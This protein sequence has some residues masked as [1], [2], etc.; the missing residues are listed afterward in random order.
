MKNKIQQNALVALPVAN[1]SPGAEGKK[2]VAQT[3]S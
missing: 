2:A 1:K 3:R